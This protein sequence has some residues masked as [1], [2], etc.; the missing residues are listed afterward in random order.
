VFRDKRLFLLQDLLYYLLVVLEKLVAI[1]AIRVLEL[2]VAR[3]V[4]TQSFGR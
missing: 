1:V 3:D 4:F 2:L